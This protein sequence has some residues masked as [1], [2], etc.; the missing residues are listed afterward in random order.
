MV[1]IV[2]YGLEIEVYQYDIHIKD[3][4]IVDIPFVMRDILEVLK[5]E[6]KRSGITTETPLDHRSMRSMINEWIAHNNLYTLNYKKEQ[7]G[8]VDLN[9]PQPWYM[10]ILYWLFSRIVL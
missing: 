10:P 2:V 3:S 5:K 4:H 6:L 7:T 9:H 1:K 8:S